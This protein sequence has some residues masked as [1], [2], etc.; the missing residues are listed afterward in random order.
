MVAATE[1]TGGVLGR[2]RTE[3]PTLPDALQRVAEQLLADPAEAALATIV[4]LAERSGT[5]TATITRFC[6]VFGFSGYAALRVAIA[7]ET[8]RA[9][10]ARWELDIGREIVPQDP[11]D[12]VLEIVASADTRAIQE[13]VARLDRE[14]LERV[15]AALA[16][17]QRVELFGIGSSGTVAAE[18]AFR[19]QRIGVVCWARSEV[20]TALTNAALL[21]PGDVAIGLSHGGRTH[22]I[23]EMLAE[24]GSHGATTV[25]VTSFPR[26]PLAEV[27]DVVLTTAA[28]ETTFR[29]EALAAVHSQ[30]LVLD[31]IYVV[32]AQRT[33]E[34]SSVAFEVTAEAVAGHRLP[35]EADDS[36]RSAGRRGRRR[37][38]SGRTRPAP[39]PEEA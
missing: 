8:G 31:L 38:T 13:T 18:M 36:R 29:A 17:A 27:A 32:L 5:S 26:S 7:T 9:A 1:P 20:H 10:Q 4:D 12:R 33:F 16:G 24:A 21:R 3:L 25:A 37:D 34:R 22:E 35:E 15:V 23:I 39:K 2:I 11:L 28:H 30:L 14:S 6:R 19:L